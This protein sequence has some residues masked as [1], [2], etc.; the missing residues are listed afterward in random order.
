M[1]ALKDSKDFRDN[2][3]LFLMVGPQCNMWCRH[4]SQMPYKPCKGFLSDEVSDDVM[5]LIGN[6]IEYYQNRKG[7]FKKALISFWGGESLLHWP[8]IR[9]VVPYFTE[10]YHMLDNLNVTFCLPSNGLLVTDEVVDF[11]NRYRVQLNLSFDAPY[12]FAVRGYVPEGTV[13]RIKKIK[14]L[15]V[16]GSLNALN[17]DLYAA[18]RCMREK[19]EESAYQIFFNFQLLYTFDM[20]EDISGFDFGKVRDGVRMCRIAIQKG[21][22][23]YG[24]AI[25]PLVESVFRPELREFQ[26]KYHLR[27]CVPG[28]RYLAVTLDGKVVRC[29]NDASLQCGTVDDSLDGIFKRSI[30]ICYGLQGKAQTEKCASCEHIDVCPGGCMMGVKDGNGYYKACDMYIKKIYSVLKEEV[31]ALNGPLSETDEKWF[32]D[33]LPFYD[34]LV[35][36]YAEGKY[37]NSINGRKEGMD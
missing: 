28:K 32:N 13:E 20:P 12:P 23:W 5:T 37:R 26:R 21:D 4:C 27:H 14:N 3:Y 15:C 36:D 34:A 24:Q 17:C 10:K 18:L 7:D 2:S 1:V 31:L 11:C 9:K 8:L 30:D 16:L 25:M 29:H 35:K 6:Y 33:R 22:G 19:F